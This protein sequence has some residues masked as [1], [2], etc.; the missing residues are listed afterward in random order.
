MIKTH[1]RTY[2][3][4][5]GLFT[6]SAAMITY[7]G[8]AIADYSL[9]YAAPTT[10]NAWGICYVVTN[11]AAP[12]AFVSTTTAAEWASVINSHGTL[13]FSS[14]GV[15]QGDG[16]CDYCGNGGGDGGVGSG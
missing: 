5:A 4:A 11:T 8:L 14:C 10:I 15:G 9:P 3:R 7:S 1:F 6:A 12:T 13:N 2:L 16:G